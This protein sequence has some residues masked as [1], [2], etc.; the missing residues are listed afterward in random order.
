MAPHGAGLCPQLQEGGGVVMVVDRNRGKAKKENTAILEMG[1]IEPGSV[2]VLLFFFFVSSTPLRRG[3][4][5][6]Y[7]LPRGGKCEP[8]EMRL[9]LCRS[10]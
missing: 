8:H 4:E 5:C 3:G 1:A 6:M 9:L 10:T 7:A 2:E